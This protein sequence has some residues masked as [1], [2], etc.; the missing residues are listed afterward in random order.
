MKHWHLC[1]RW[2]KAGIE[3]PCPLSGFAEHEDEREDEDEI[4]APSKVP[5]GIIPARKTG[6][7]GK[8]GKKKRLD[9]TIRQ[10]LLDARSQGVIK[11]LGEAIPVVPTGV[12]LPQP[13]TPRP[14]IPVP[15]GG[16]GS[17][18]QGALASEADFF[19]GGSNEKGQGRIP[20]AAAA[21]LN[22]LISQAG[23]QASPTRTADIAETAVTETI[24]RFIQGVSGITANEI[25]E[26][27]A[28]LAVGGAGAVAGGGFFFNATA[29]MQNLIGKA[30]GDFK[31]SADQE[32]PNSEEPD[33]ENS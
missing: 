23:P 4:E 20:T 24:H 2:R 27:T 26:L 7:S 33:F 5:R 21:A 13:Q 32:G 6:G 3:L 22:V 30:P 8:S 15:T 31:L 28:I 10:I 11:A 18:G 12:P 1:E 14:G 19:R 17:G 16:S 9:E 29:R 25:A